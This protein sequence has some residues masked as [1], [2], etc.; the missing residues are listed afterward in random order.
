MIWSKKE[1]D[2]GGYFPI[3]GTCLGF[4]QMFVSMTGLKVSTFK[5]LLKTLIH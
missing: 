3:W 1:A 2:L 5:F 4:E